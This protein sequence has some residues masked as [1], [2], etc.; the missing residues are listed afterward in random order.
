MAQRLFVKHGYAGTSTKR[1]AMEAGVAEALVFHHFGTKEALL[2]ALLA[3]AGTF[4][5]EVAVRVFDTTPRSARKR[6]AEIAALYA[7]VSPSEAAF[8]TFM[9]GELHAHVALA[10]AVAQGTAQ[11]TAH[12]VAALEQR[13]VEGE[14]RA[15]ADLEAC[16]VG[17]F[18]G[19]LNFFQLNRD[20]AERTWKRRAEDFATAWADQCWR[21]IARVERMR[22]TGDE[23]PS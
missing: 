16:L 7:K 14:L 15:D 4:A 19:F 9:N 10:Q 13:V 23:V 17:F 6:F 8:V 12:F 18:G 1:I 11:V 21:G 2:H 5:G 22:D 3:R 20:V